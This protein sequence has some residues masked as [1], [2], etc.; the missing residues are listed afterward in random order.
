MTVTWHEALGREREFAVAADRLQPGT[1]VIVAGGPGSGRT[2]FASALA[3]TARRRGNA[4]LWIAAT[5]SLREL[6]FGA[7]GWMLGR[8][9]NTAARTDALATIG[10]GLRFHDGAT[11]TTL[12][13]DDAHL[14]DEHSADAVLQAVSTRAVGV[15]LT[16][17]AG[18]KLPTGV[19]R[20]ANDGFVSAIELKPFDRIE[21]ARVITELLS[22]EP[23]PSTV[24]LLLRWSGGVAATLGAIVE[25]GRREDRFVPIQGQWWWVGEAPAP[26]VVT[27]RIDRRLTELDPLSA[28]A[29]AAVAIAEWMTAGEL[30]RLHGSTALVQLED[31]GLIETR[32]DGMQLVVRCAGGLVAQTVVGRL[33]PLR[34]RELSRRCLAMLAAPAAADELVRAARLS[35][36]AGP[37]HP[38][39]PS[40]DLMLRAGSMLRLSEPSV[41]HRLVE[42]GHRWSPSVDSQVGLLF[43]LLEHGDVE[44]ASVALEAATRSIEARG[45]IEIEQERVRLTEAEFAVELFGR[46][47]ARAA[48]EVVEAARGC[49]GTGAY[50]AA[51]DS[52]EAQSYMMS[53]RPDRTRP[54]AQRVLDGPDASPKA[55]LRAGIA[56]STTMMLA[57]ETEAAR[58][59]AVALLD[60]ARQ[61]NAVMPT[62]AGM[63]QAQLAFI[64]LWRGEMAPL[65]AAHP[66]TGRWPAPPA[67]GGCDDAD[68]SSPTFTW[69][70]LAGIVAHLRG[71][72][73]E[74]VGRLRE[75]VVQQSSG[76]GIFQAEAH[77]WLAVALCDSGDRTEADA[78]MR[79]YP[80]RCLTVLPGLSSWAHGVIACAA[81]RLEDGEHL[82]R[83]A[84]DEAAAVGASLCEARYLVELA[85]RC[86]S[87]RVTV[88]LAALADDIDAW[89][90]QLLCRS[91][92]ARSDG[93]IDTLLTTASQ[94]AERGFAVRAATI[95]RDAERLARAEGNTQQ[96][97]SAARIRRRRSRTAD[98]AIVGS[99]AVA[100]LTRREAEVAGLAAGGLTDRQIAARLVVSVRTV[101][102][103][104]ASSY[105]KLDVAS[106]TDLSIALA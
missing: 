37:A 23:A 103:H 8:T 56:L 70:L 75:A 7:F 39:D 40:T 106:R 18:A 55:K 53:A 13:V 47:D 63:L 72:H 43:D 15:V 99:G 100:R 45:T 16:V 14:L 27:E 28:D 54:I 30:E 89:L 77:A 85:E 81:G 22:G 80:E 96:A 9:A 78:V 74:A 95:A 68:G 34:A 98:A 46:R 58:R 19:A 31:A 101:E 60:Q 97:R 1:G 67:G 35:I 32:D 17:D 11:P 5:E 52:M 36:H 59:L 29:L 20:L 90:L 62:A 61:S 4:P 49:A 24:E 38:I 50:R 92:V 41:A 10:S 69:A 2:A 94:L 102:S 65:L 79:T 42:A 21:I 84:A 86:D 6:P 51:L 76:R 48:R 33:A 12:I 3:D 105:R 26:D 82:L 44:G 88:R 71:E 93:D 66:A 25:T 57:G 87:G 73:S 91:A 64:Q 104:L 83:S